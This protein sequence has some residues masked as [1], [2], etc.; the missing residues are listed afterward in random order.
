MMTEY[1]NREKLLDVREQRAVAECFEVREDGATGSII[2]QGYA[3]TFEPYDVHGGPDAGGWVEQ[4]SPRCLDRTLAEQPDLQLLINHEGTPL[5]RT[6]SGTLQL[7]RD[8]HGLRVRAS[9]DPSDPDVQRL[10]PKMRRGDMDEMSFAFRVKD[11]SWDSS[12]T[13]RTINELS[14]QKGDVSVVNYGMNPRTRAILSADAV[15]ALA[16]LSGKELVEIRKAGTIDMEQVRRAKQVLA[17]LEGRAD[18]DAKKP[19]GDVPYADP[20]YQKDGKKRYPIDTKAHAKA[21]WSYISMPKNQKGYSA[22]Q[23]GSIKGRIRSA[24]KKF[25]VDVSDDKKALSDVGPGTEVS[26]IDQHRNAD[27]GTTLVAVMTDGSRVPLPSQRVSTQRIAMGSSPTPSDMP[28][29]DAGK[30]EAFVGYNPTWNPGNVESE[31]PHNPLLPFAKGTADDMEKPDLGPV[32]ANIIGEA[33]PTFKPADYTW[34]PQSGSGDPHNVPADKIT[35]SAD[36]EEMGTGVN[37]SGDAR[38]KRQDDDDEEDAL[39]QDDDDEED[40]LRSQRAAGTCADCG[41]PMLADARFCSACGAERSAKRQDDDDEDDALRGDDPHDTPFAEVYNP[42]TGDVTRQDDEDACDDLEPIDLGLAAALD[43]TIVHAYKLA[44]GNT[45]LRKLLTTAR[46]Q[47]NT[48]RGA[49]P[50]KDSDVARKLAELRME[51]GQPDTGTVSDSL[52]WLRSEGSAPVGYG[53]LLAHDPDLRLRTAA[54]R[55]GQEQ[56]AG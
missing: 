2:L 20:G 45:D 6:K 46:Q 18:D 52:K 36:N 47:L 11:Q 43:R 12:Y 30:H 1:R 23:V 39:R 7:S 49:K 42:E 4:L 5:A 15:G 37:V 48:L 40:G 53:G 33:G 10:I 26:Y 3:A 28:Q 41:A 17:A 27:G 8:R 54:D 35:L 44:E 24:L 38:P 25:G 55:L 50:Q 32:P 56:K 22:E 34:N 9:L 29:P 31:D 21:A 14:L 51:T 13:R 16:S 19:Y